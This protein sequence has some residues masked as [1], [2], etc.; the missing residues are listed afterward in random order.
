MT[1]S[2]GEDAAASLLILI[3][4]RPELFGEWD[5]GSRVVLQWRARLPDGAPPSGQQW[6]SGDPTVSSTYDSLRGRGGETAVVVDLDPAARAAAAVRAVC[7]ACPDAAV[8]VLSRGPAVP[9]PAGVTARHVPWPELLRLDLEAKLVELACQRRV[10]RLRAFAR[11]ASQV[12]ILVQRDPD[13][14]AIASALAVRT[15]LGRADED[16]PILTLGEVT[17]PENRRMIRLLDVEIRQVE[18]QELAALACLVTVDT[19]PP[20]LDGAPVRL[21]VIDHHPPEAGVDVE[22]CDIRPEYGATAT[23]LTEY[24]R[25]DGETQID[26]RLA[27]ALLYGIQTDTALLTRASTAN[28]VAAYAFLQDRAD[29]KLLRRISRP[30]YAPD[31]MRAFGRA[32][33]G[34]IVR[35]GLAVAHVGALSSDDVHILADLADF[36]LSIDG[37]SWVAVGAYVGGDLTVT[38]RHLGD[39]GPGAGVLARRLAVPGGQGG[40]HAT[41]A[42]LVLPAREAER[43]FRGRTD[44]GV[45][46]ALALLVRTELEQLR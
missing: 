39:D 11:G 34:L 41:M 23:M 28:D 45:A 44:G 42:R 36:C 1:R 21:A 18:V 20:S 19:Q 43:R 29:A 32:L 9:L 15:L 8:L 2:T 26:G 22:V 24:L 38:L 14:D 7:R 4:E 27:T 31:A 13:P 10:D 17:R 25:A 46:S 12:P 3:S 30:S 16:C 37:V 33:S 35:D 40:G 6:F 5:E